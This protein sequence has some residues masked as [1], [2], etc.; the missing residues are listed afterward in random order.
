MQ[1][2]ATYCA[3][4]QLKGNGTLRKEVDQ[5]YTASLTKPIVGLGT[6][7]DFYQH[8]AVVCHQAKR[9]NHFRVV[10]LLL[11][12]EARLRRGET[13][14]T[15]KSLKI[16]HV[17]ATF[18]SACTSERMVGIQIIEAMTLVETTRI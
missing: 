5:F 16:Q 18:R 17:V 8:D 11:F 12:A 3:K 6:V 13:I 15:L 14:M 4:Q 10:F 9:S 1:G 2:I 7:V